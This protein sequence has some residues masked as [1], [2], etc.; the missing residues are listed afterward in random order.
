MIEKLDFEML[1]KYDH[2]GRQHILTPFP[3]G[4]H[5]IRLLPFA[6]HQE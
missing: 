4:K 1:D 3:F 6:Y 2:N 5:N